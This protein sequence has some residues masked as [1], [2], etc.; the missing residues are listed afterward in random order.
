MASVQPEASN[1]SL[2]PGPTTRGFGLETKLFLLSAPILEF[3]RRRPRAARAAIMTSLRLSGAFI[4]SLVCKWASVRGGV[5]AA[6][7]RN[8]R[9]LIVPSF[10]AERW[11]L[12]WELSIE[13]VP[14]TPCTVGESLEHCRPTVT[15]P[16][17]GRFSLT[18]QFVLLCTIP[19]STANRFFPVRGICEGILGSRAFSLDAVYCRY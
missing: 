7:R 6:A 9:L 14:T 11:A 15:R 16:F 10:H 17:L 2:W 19:S 4:R 3:R 13:A 5:Q 1:D 18:M 12:A 8:R